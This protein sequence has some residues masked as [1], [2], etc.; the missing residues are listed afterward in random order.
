MDLFTAGTIP[1]NLVARSQ[2]CQI[3]CH[4]GDHY[5]LSELKRCIY[6]E[7]LLSRRK[8][9]GL[10]IVRARIQSMPSTRQMHGQQGLIKDTKT[11]SKIYSL[12]TSLLTTIDLE[13]MATLV[14]TSHSAAG[15]H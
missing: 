12:C 5:A 10:K 15:W 2:V 4:D 6:L 7:S 11:S 9:Q 13:S 1:L 14:S 8:G 3:L